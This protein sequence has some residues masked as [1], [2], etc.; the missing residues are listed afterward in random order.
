MIPTALLTLLLAGAPLAPPPVPAAAGAAALGFD[1]ARLA[2]LETVMRGFLDR[3]EL[4]GAVLRITRDGREVAHLTMGHQD[5]AR[6]VPMRPD[7]LFRIA[8]MTKPVTTVAA[9]VLLEEGRLRLEDPVSKFL[10]AFK[11]PQVAVPGR[12][13]APATRVKAAREITIQDLMT[14]RSGISYSW[15]GTG[16]VQEA[17][18]A[19]GLTDG[20]VD[21]GLDLEANMALLAQAPLVQEPG[22]AFHYGLSTDVLG[23]VVEVASGMRLDAFMEARIFRPLGMR[24]T[25]FGVAPEHA[26]RLAEAV[27][28]GE[29]GRLRPV[30]APERFNLVNLAPGMVLKPGPRYLSGGAGLVSTATDYARFCNMLLNRGELDGVRI[31]SPK[32]VELMTASAT[33]DLPTVAPG[34]EFGLGVAVVTDLGASRQLGSPGLYAWSGLYGSVFWVDPKERVVAV[35][36]VQ[37]F[38]YGGVDWMGAFRTQVY[39]AL[40]R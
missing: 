25:G 30:R 3:G 27:T 20:L 15:N 5:A 35:L 17:Y 7:S 38:P 9:L 24:D 28:A 18:R 33:R 31:L 14:H 13:G 23:R 4:P 26:P 36:M 1:P 19:L 6:T 12:D 37:R 32:T 2:R 34:M 29:G 11:E 10:P 8:S 22:K 16:P 21:P 39:Q 40:V